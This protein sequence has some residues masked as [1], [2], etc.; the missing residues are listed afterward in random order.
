MQRKTKHHRHPT[1]LGTLWIADVVL[2]LLLWPAGGP[3]PVGAVFVMW[4]VPTFALVAVT[5]WWLHHRREST[6]SP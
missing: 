6:H 3:A 2:V 5:W 1:V 4:L